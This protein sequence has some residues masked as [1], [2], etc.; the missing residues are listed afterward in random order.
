[1]VDPLL[2][3]FPR[4]S[5]FF[6]SFIIIICVYRE[7]EREGGNRLDFVMMDTDR[8]ERMG[9]YVDRE[10]TRTQLGGRTTTRTKRPKSVVEGMGNQMKVLGTVAQLIIRLPCLPLELEKISRDQIK[11]GGVPRFTSELGGRIS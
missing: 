1:M 5:V 3:L 7:R 11:G 6:E 8:K 2:S 10:I 9:A 4:D